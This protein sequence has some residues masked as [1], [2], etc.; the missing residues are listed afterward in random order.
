M[1]K[2]LKLLTLKQ[3]LKIYRYGLKKFIQY[4]KNFYL[5]KINNI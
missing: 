1:H 5:N 4:I 3:S 2:Q